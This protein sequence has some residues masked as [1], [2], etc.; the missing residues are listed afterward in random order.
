MH[1]SDGEVILGNMFTSVNVEIAELICLNFIICLRKWSFQSCTNYECEGGK[2]ARSH[3]EPVRSP[4]VASI[5]I[6][7]IY[8]LYDH[9]EISFLREYLL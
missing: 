3:A 4:R 6:K 8:C 5:T 1:Y 2:I 7:I 9:Y